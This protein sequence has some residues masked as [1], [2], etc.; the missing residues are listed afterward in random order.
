M[1]PCPHCPQKPN[2]SDLQRYGFTL[3]NGAQYWTIIKEIKACCPIKV[4]LVD[5]TNSIVTVAVNGHQYTKTRKE[6]MESS[7]RDIDSY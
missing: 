6:F 7:W 1:H 2:Q 5:H 3:Y 4:T